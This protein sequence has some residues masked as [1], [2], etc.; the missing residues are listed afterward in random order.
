MVNEGHE[1]YGGNIAKED[2]YG[3]LVVD[4]RCFVQ[5]FINIYVSN[6]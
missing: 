2:N 1:K 6:K 5:Y 4:D 3:N